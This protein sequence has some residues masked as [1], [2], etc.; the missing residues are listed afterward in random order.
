LK[1]REYKLVYHDTRKVALRVE[2]YVKTYLNFSI[3]PSPIKKGSASGICV[4]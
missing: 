3:V 4:E 2:Y 1:A